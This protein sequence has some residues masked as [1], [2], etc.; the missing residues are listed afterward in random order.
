[1]KQIL[2]SLAILLFACNLLQAQER[3]F[4]RGATYGELY[5]SNIWYWINP[6]FMDTLYKAVYRCTEYG[7]KLT[8][9]SS[10]EEFNTPNSEMKLDVILADATPGVIYNKYNDYTHTQLYVS[11][12]YGKNWV[13]KDENSGAYNDNFYYGTNAEGVIYRGGWT[14][15]FKSINYGEDFILMENIMVGREPGLN[16]CEFFTL[17]NNCNY[18]SD[19]WQSSISIPIDPE[20]NSMLLEN[21]IYRGGLP[22]EVYVSSVFMATGNGNR[23]NTRG[24]LLP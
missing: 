6:P 22:G 17:G 3:Y 11:F 1:M 16:D 24:Y 20:Y 8:I 13:L 4:A 9:Q 7:K 12:D 14:G 21:D 2:L 10:A 15:A 18:T 19:C 23:T 5:M